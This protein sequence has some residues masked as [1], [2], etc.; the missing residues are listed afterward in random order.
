MAFDPEK[1]L[2]HPS[3]ETPVT[4]KIKA[5]LPITEAEFIDG[6]EDIR[7]AA[8]VTRSWQNWNRSK[9]GQE[10]MDEKNFPVLP[11]AEYNGWARPGKMSDEMKLFLKLRGE[12]VD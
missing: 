11:Y 12:K 1:N 4:R 2:A 6:F 5:R 8:R 10:L 3:G 9:I 7:E